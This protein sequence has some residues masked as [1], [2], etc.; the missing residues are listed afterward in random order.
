MVWSILLADDEAEYVRIQKRC[1]EKV[2]G[3][4]VYAANNGR[5]A[6]EIIEKE[7]VDIM[8]LDLSMPVMDGIELLTELHNRHIWLPVLILTGR[9]IRSRERPHREFGIVEFLDKPVKFEDLKEKMESILSAG[10]KRVVFY[11]LSLV[12][13]LAVLEMERKTGVLTI[14]LEKEDGRI[15]FRDGV[16]ADIEVNGF[17]LKEAMSECLKYENRERRI[18]IEFGEHGKK[19]RID[20]WLT[21]LLPESS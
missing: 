13:M 18:A 16:V 5:E 20:K 6:L 4:I 19:S 7:T 12:T 2:G 3:Y 11:G 9:R 1:L 14:H 21:E 8:V 10:T 17:S 15:Y